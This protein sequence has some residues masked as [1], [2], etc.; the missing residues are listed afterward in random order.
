MV[1]A[2]QQN[3]D[4]GESEAIALALESKAN[5]LLMDERLGWD[6]ARY[7]DLYFTRILGI[8]IESKRKGIVTDIKQ[9]LDKL[10]DK[11]GFRV[12]EPLYKRVLRDSGEMF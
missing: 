2:L 5:L 10:R 4:A 12:S 11:A 1:R 6:T 3:L 9:L 7:M 8:F